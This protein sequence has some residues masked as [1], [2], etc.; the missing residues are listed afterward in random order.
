[1]DKDQQE[2]FAPMDVWPNYAFTADSR[3]VI[4]PHQG[5]VLKV[6][7]DSG[8]TQ[9]IAFRA[10]VEQT[11]APQVTWQE[12]IDTGPVHARILRWTTESPD[13]KWIAFDA[14]GRVWLQE[15]AAGKPVGSPKRLTSGTL[16]AR[17]YAP[18]FSPDGR[19]IAYVTWS[20]TEGGQL[21][22]APTAGGAPRQLTR[23]PGH[24]ANPSWSPKGDRL[25][26]IRGSGLEFR[27]Q[28]PEDENFFEIHW[29]DANGGD[30]NLV[31]TVTTANAMRF[32]PQAF[33]APDGTR[34][35]YRKSVEQT[36]PTD[37]LQ[38]DVVSIRLDGT[39]RK[40]H[41]RLPAVDDLVPSP[42]GQWVAFTSR[43]NV[44]VAALPMT[45]TKEP[46][47]VGAKEGAVPVWRL[48]D[49]AGASVAW[50]ANGT[51]IT[52]SLGDTFHRLP[53]AD[54]MKFVQDQKAK[55]VSDEAKAEAKKDEQEKDEAARP[56]VSADPDH[57]HHAAAGAAGIVRAARGARPDDEARRGRA[58]RDSRQRRR[59]R[60]RQPDRGDR[61]RSIGRDC[62]P[63][64][65]S[66]MRKA[67][68]SFPGSSIR[69]RTCTTP[70]SRRSRKRSGNT[71]RTSPTASPRSTTRR[72]TRSTSSRRARWWKPGS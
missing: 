36:K 69:T 26:L 31:T 72:R 61:A 67:R 34:L 21:W 40:T 54:A 53:F 22:S 7:L 18:A 64:P 29:I 70:A 9:K 12:R 33:W 8:D 2:G 1:M 3:H 50:A 60:D 71:S 30:T 15:I 51:V 63:G 65:G 58:R 47:T 46:A 20:D 24:Y 27:G 44:Y 19:S 38:N 52:W 25:A 11:F 14:F 28:Q 62:R 42:D 32:H 56:F 6:A 23:A 39:D 41:L 49:A 5:S 10:T 55:A 68:R 57:A 48:S 13:G 66:S 16:P 35:I 37:P 45:Q 17:E 59:G 43:D 4:V